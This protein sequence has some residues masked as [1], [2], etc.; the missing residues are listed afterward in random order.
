MP[1][2]RARALVSWSSGKDSAWALHEI[3]SAG[4]IDVLG[5][6][7]TFEPRFAF[8]DIVNASPEVPT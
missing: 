5:L 3:R 4:R 8:T 7:T 2:P 6:L 1:R